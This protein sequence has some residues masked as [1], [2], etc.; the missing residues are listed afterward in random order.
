MV[1]GLPSCQDCRAAVAENRSHRE[2]EVDREE[3]RADVFLSALL[4]LNAWDDDLSWELCHFDW[5]ARAGALA[6]CHRR[7]G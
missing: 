4:H 6:S 1:A 5:V 7:R 2:L 3:G